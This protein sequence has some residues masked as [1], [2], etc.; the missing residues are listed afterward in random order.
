MFCIYSQ[1][2]GE[3]HGM[4]QSESKNETYNNS[5]EHTKESLESL[6]LNHSVLL[7]HGQTEASLPSDSNFKLVAVKSTEFNTD[8]PV[9]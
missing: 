4:T 6:L 2:Y 5:E 1:D 9:G 3:G 8:L 7:G